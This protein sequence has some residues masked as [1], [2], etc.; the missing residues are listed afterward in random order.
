MGLTRLSWVGKINSNGLRLLE[1]CSE[2]KLVICNTFFHHKDK[3][4]YTWFHPKSKQ[5]H[6][7]DYIITRKRDLADVCNVQV[8]CRA[9]CDTNH[10]L[11]RGKFKLHICK[12]IPL[13]G[14][15][16]P[17][18][19]DVSKLHDLNSIILTLMV[20]GIGSKNKYTQWVWNLLD[21]NGK[22]NKIGL[23]KMTLTSTSCQKS[24]AFIVTY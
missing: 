18:Q 23:M 22:N 12:K 4:K 2:L 17:K 20:L 14:V 16:V 19:L 1:L 8:L 3:H 6:L 15:K 24:D 21:Y 13:S 11:V 5:G 10:R 7:I 9:E